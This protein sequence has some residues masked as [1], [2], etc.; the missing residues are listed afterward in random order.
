MGDGARVPGRPRSPVLRPAARARSR[1]SARPAPWRATVRPPPRARGQG[2]ARSRCRLRPPR[3]PV[4]RGRSSRAQPRRARAPALPRAAAVRPRA[5]PRSRPVPPLTARALRFA[6]LAL[7]TGRPRRPDVRS[8]RPPAAGPADAGPGPAAA[9]PP[10][11]AAAHPAAHRPGHRAGVREHSTSAPPP[12]RRRH[13]ARHGRRHMS[14][15]ATPRAAVASTAPSPPAREHHRRGS[16]AGR[17]RCAA[18]VGAR[19]EAGAGSRRRSRD[20][21]GCAQGLRAAR[22]SSGPIRRRQNSTAN[23]APSPD[24][25]PRDQTRSGRTRSPP[26]NGATTPAAPCIPAEPGRL[27]QAASIGHRRPRR[28]IRRARRHTPNRRR[29]RARHPEPSLRHHAARTVRRTRRHLRTHTPAAS[30]TRPMPGPATTPVGHRRSPRRIPPRR[31]HTPNRRRRR[32]PV[33]TAASE[34]GAPFGSRDSSTIG[35]SSV[36][37]GARATIARIRAASPGAGKVTV[38]TA[39]SPRR[40]LTSPLTAALPALLCRRITVPRFSGGRDWPAPASAESLTPPVSA[41]AAPVGAGAAGS[42]C[43]SRSPASATLARTY[44]FTTSTDRARWA[45]TWAT[46]SP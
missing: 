45:A 38:R 39:E 34:A 19:Q 7:T 28:R 13:R 11:T 41:G 10:V 24:P 37:T 30:C 25:S 42:T 5:R 35:R 26:A 23:P 4:R 2:R 29:R 18:A 1:P 8:A 32:T 40:P 22:P 43:C 46:L 14:T 27:R 36:A 15:P 3:A 17:R 6:A 21:H 9:S 33:G 12:R 20:R 16:G 44:M 31:R